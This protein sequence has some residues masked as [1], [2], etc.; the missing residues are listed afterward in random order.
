MNTTR[1]LRTCAALGLLPLLFTLSGCFEPD[2][3]PHPN[4]VLTKRI[5]LFK[6]LSHAMEPLNDIRN[7][8]RAFDAAQVLVDAKALDALSVQPW[9][10]FPLDGNYPPTRAL[11]GIWTTPEDFD[12]AKDHFLGA[13]D[14][15]V[16][17][18]K[19]GNPAQV[20]HAIDA[21]SE[22]CKACHRDFRR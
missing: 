8:R 15:L 16:A 5:A 10:Y 2:K 14:N 18:A 19:A 21:V 6:Q 22:S 4:Q 1:L 9:R 11:P 12:R 3:D 13:V 7:G 20:N 17:A